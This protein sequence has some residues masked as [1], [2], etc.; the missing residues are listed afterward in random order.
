M[1]NSNLNN[2]NLD[3]EIEL[4]ELLRIILNSKKLIFIVTLA[5]SLLAFIYTNQKEREYQSTVILEIGS[6]DLLNGEKKFVES[7]VSLK[8]KLN[9]NINFKEQSK[10]G[11]NKL[12]FKDIEDQLL[13]INYTSPS[14]EFNE[15]LLKSAVTFTQESHAEILDNI[16]NSFSKKIVDKY[17]EIEFL[18]NSIESQQESQKLNAVNALKAIDAEIEFLKNSIESQQ[19]SQ[20]LNAIYLINTIDNQIHLLEA[21]IRYLLKLI[22]EEENNLLLLKSNPSALLQRTIVSPTLQ[23]IIYSYNEETISLRNQI[24]NLLQE[25]E[26]LE[27]QVKSI[28]EGEVVSEALFKLNQEKDNLE[29]QVKSIEEGEVV[30]KSLFNLNLEKD[31]LELQVK[32]IKDKKRA[33]QP[34]HESETSEIKIQTLPAILFGTILGFI[35]SI[36]IVFIRQ[37]FLKGQN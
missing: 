13:E 20:K 36:I 16:V 21:K 8:K 9:V 3:D 24:Q 1:K 11:G 19:E 5:F 30:S 29:L 28:E 23:Q 12:N 31:N 17:K 15:N 37:A 25:K 26:T 2:E 7:V 6:Y 32:L 22:P 18:K 10:L 34:I 33:T 14:P 27:L 35:L 4:V